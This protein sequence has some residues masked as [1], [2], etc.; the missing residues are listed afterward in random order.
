GPDGAMYFV[1]GGRKTQSGLYRVTYTGP[2]VRPR[3]LTRAES[4]RATRTKTFREERKKAE[5]HH[6]QAKFAFE[7]AHTEP[8]IRHA[9][10]I[11]LE[12]NKL[13]PGK[14]DTP[15][16]ENLSAQSNIDSSRGSAKVTLLDN[17]PKLL[18]SEQLAYLDLIRR[19]MKRHEL[20]AKTLAEIQSNLQPHFPSHSPKVN[21]ALAPLLIQLNPAKAVAQTIKLLEASMNQTERISYLYH[22]RHAKQ[23]W[24]SESR[25]TFFRILGTYDTFLGGRGLPKALKKIRAEAGATLTNTEKK[26]LAE[27]IDQKPALP[28][29]P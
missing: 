5:F 9:W 13:T 29:L 20:P 17:W 11:A 7:L 8:R 18:P 15:N 12:H 19:T 10:R 2:V 26:E 4:N 3:P 22:L 14:E 28:P 23:G 1:T 27:V 25:R 16:F 24:T 21:Q 6:C